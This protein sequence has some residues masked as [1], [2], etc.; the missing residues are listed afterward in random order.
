MKDMEEK[1]FCHKGVYNAISGKRKSFKGLVWLYKDNCTEEAIENK[2]A[3]TK[4]YG[5]RV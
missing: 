1:G 5:R 4:T 3:I 2:I